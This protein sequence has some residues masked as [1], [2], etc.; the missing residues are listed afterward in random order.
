MNNVFEQKTFLGIVFSE[1]RDP[2]PKKISDAA[3]SGR[4]P[5]QPKGSQ[6]RSVGVSN[7]S[8]TVG[9]PQK[10][11]MFD[12]KYYVEIFCLAKVMPKTRFLA[13]VGG[14]WGAGYSRDPKNSQKIHN[15][16]FGFHF[17]PILVLQVPCVL[18]P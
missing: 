6:N 14:L 3:R 2:R 1:L 13:S 12:T 8:Q 4:D 15:I 18:G 17:W 16:G 10:N 5:R 11:D 9:H 7:P